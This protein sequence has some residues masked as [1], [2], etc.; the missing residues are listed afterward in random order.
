MEVIFKTYSW[1][2]LIFVFGTIVSII[3]LILIPFLLMSIKRRQKELISSIE[4]LIVSAES[5][6]I[7]ASPLLDAGA[8]ALQNS[9]ECPDCK[10]L[11]DGAYGDC[12]FCNHKFS[13]K[14]YV[15]II[16]PGDEVTLNKAAQ[17]LAQLLKIDFHEIKHRLRMG[18]DYAI[19]DRSKRMELMSGLEKMG[20]TVKE[21]VKWV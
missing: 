9:K 20:C 21:V 19:L 10:K 16:G 11:I 8:E 12:P 7:K 1:F 14:Y 17:K 15:N 5:I 13:K 4:E 6:I 3:A 18:F 2:P